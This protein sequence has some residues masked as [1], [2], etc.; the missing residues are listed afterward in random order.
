MPLRRTVPITEFRKVLNSVRIASM[1]DVRRAI[2]MPCEGCGR[3]LLEIALAPGARGWAAGDQPLGTL[4]PHGSSSPSSYRGQP[5]T[6]PPQAS[7]TKRGL[8]NR[9]PILTYQIHLGAWV[10]RSH[11]IQCRV[12]GSFASRS[13]N[14][15]TAPIQGQQAS[16]QPA[17]SYV[18]LYQDNAHCPLY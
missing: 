9:L 3:K 6:T 18:R 2:L 17:L 5:N 4:Q 10:I 11:R 8:P 15:S 1:E 7:R 14:G 12:I 16:T 13:L